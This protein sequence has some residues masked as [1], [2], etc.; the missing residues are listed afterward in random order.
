MSNR[1]EAAPTTATGGCNWYVRE[2]ATD[3]KS[4][5]VKCYCVGAGDAREIAA[6]LNH[7]DAITS[8]LWSTRTP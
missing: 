1:Y 4:A 3:G 8:H 5:W 6:A 7:I 2:N